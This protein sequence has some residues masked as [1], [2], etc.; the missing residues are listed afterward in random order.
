[1]MSLRDVMTLGVSYS[2]ICQSVKKGILPLASQT[3]AHPYG[4]KFHPE[5]VRDFQYYTQGR[6]REL[7]ERQIL[8][9][10]RDPVNILKCRDA[11]GLGT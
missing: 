7:M 4:Y 5:D 9:K 2:E 1:M 8:L 10:M 11:L 6:Q 3:G